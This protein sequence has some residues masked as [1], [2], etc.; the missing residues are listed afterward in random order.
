MHK[1]SKNWK[2]ILLEKSEEGFIVI[3]TSPLV[4][5]S[6][7]NVQFVTTIILKDSNVHGPVLLRNV[8]PLIV[9]FPFE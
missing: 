6:S 9:K 8:H 4:P 5:I 1:S 3:V 2:V 7:D